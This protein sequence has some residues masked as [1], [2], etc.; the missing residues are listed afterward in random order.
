M[1]AKIGRIRNI[2]ISILF[3]DMEKK[4][5]LKVVAAEEQRAVAFSLY[6]L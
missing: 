5:R 4:K 2:N 3:R 1:M 6:A